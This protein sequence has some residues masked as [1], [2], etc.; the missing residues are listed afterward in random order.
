MRQP[1]KTHHVVGLHGVL[2]GLVG[3]LERHAQCVDDPCR[4]T[5]RQKVQHRVDV[6][7]HHEAAAQPSKQQD[8]NI[9]EN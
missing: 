2:L 3:V 6:I 8:E 7:L 9:C 1:C 5:Q 4:G